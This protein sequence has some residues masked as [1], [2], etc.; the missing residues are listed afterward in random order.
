MQEIKT[1][2]P[3]VVQALQEWYGADPYA[4]RFSHHDPSMDAHWRKAK[5]LRQIGRI[6]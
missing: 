3:L 2:A 5:N 6:S 1:V 4:H